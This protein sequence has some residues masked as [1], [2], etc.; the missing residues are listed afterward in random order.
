MRSKIQFFFGKGWTGSR[1]EKVFILAA[2]FCGLLINADYSIVRPVSNSV[3]LSFFSSTYLPYVW[4]GALPINF[5]VVSLY[6]RYLPKLGCWRIFL[7]IAGLIALGNILGALFLSHAPY[8]SIVHFIWKEIYIL[9]L[10]QTLWSLIHMT[11]SM[12]RAKALYGV[13]FG[14]GGLGAVLGSFLPGFCATGMGSETLL[15]FSLPILISLSLLYRKAVNFSSPLQTHPTFHDGGG[16]PAPI[17]TG[18]KLITSSKVLPYILLLVVFMQL[19]STLIDYQFNSFLQETYPE[20]NLRTEFLG[21][22]GSLVSLLTSLLQF[23]GSF[24]LI[25]LFGLRGTHFLVPIVLG[26]NALSSLFWPGLRTLAFSFGSIKVFDFS[27]FGIVKE[28]LYVNLSPEEKFQA[29]ALIDVFAYRGAKALA[30]LVILGL[31]A[32]HLAQL[33]FLSLSCLVIFILWCFSL[34]ALF[35]REKAMHRVEDMGQSL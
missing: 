16:K 19:A 20:K 35:R 34:A 13:M 6:N 1:Q 28:M 26:C 7:A 31:Q 5:A 32:V 22:L 18:I 14:F 21:R 23:L 8:L 24:A 29:K 3:F 12:E 17:S 11:V 33:H 30:A 9:L 2:M 27:L 25:K 4:L 10:F 15:F